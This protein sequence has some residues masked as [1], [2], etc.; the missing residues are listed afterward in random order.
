MAKTNVRPGHNVFLLF[1]GDGRL[2]S[3][4]HFLLYKTLFLKISSVI[5][6]DKHS[7]PPFS[8]HSPF[9]EDNDRRSSMYKELEEQLNKAFPASMTEGSVDFLTD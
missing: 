2:L 8:Y 9:S 4:A 1:I 7:S 6:F 5:S 3:G